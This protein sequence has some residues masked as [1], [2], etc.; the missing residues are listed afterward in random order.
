[1]FYNCIQ[2]RKKEPFLLFFLRILLYEYQFPKQKTMK[3]KME[4]GKN[5]VKLKQ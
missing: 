3:M 4:T 1:M 2:F 5:N